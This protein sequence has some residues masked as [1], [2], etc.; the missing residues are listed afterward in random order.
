MEAPIVYTLG[1]S[2]SHAKKYND[3][4]NDINE[5]ITLI[6]IRHIEGYLTKIGFDMGIDETV[7]YNITVTN[8]QVNVANDNA[9]INATINNGIDHSELS[10]LIIAVR[11]S[12]ANV[13]SAEDA[14]AV[15]GSLEIIESELKQEKP[16]K[17]FIQ[18]AIT[19]L[20]SVKSTVE[21]SAAVTALVQ[22]ISTIT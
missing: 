19:T 10:K 9:T 15:E 21:F 16:R 2:Y 1:H 8:G 22:F 7:K 20:K 12:L 14:S 3:I 13:Q 4:L 17:N 18:T 6:L 11:E 5:R